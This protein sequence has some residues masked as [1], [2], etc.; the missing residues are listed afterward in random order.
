MLFEKSLQNYIWKTA[1]KNS[2]GSK[3]RCYSCCNSENAEALHITE[4]DPTKQTTFILLHQSKIRRFAH[5]LRCPNSD[6]SPKLCH[7]TPKFQK[8][9]NSDFETIPFENP[10]DGAKQFDAM[11]QCH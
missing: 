11:R 8:I 3:D 7:E 2:Q 5:I 10:I 4:T 1:M 9:P 6:S